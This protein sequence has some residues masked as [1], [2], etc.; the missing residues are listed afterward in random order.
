MNDIPDNPQPAETMPTRPK[1]SGRFRSVLE[2]ITSISLVAAAVTV[3]WSHFGRVTSTAAPP[4]SSRPEIASPA[5][6]QSLDGAHL[7]GN[8]QA[9]VGMI[10]YS[11]F[12]CP[13]CGRFARD[14]L[15]KLDRTYVQTGRVVFGFR[16]LPLEKIHPFAIKAAEAAECGAG[17]GRF[18]EMHDAMFLGT[19][20]LDTPGLLIAA[21]VAGLNTNEAKACIAADGSKAIRE[22][23]AR[24]AA[25][26]LTST[27]V[28]LIGRI[29]QGGVRVSKVLRGAQPFESFAAVLDPLFEVK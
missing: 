24:A 19:A 22:D 9:P 23:M 29:E 8:L 14:I 18:W 16:H 20:T 1:S 10:A 13:F 7:K 27:P 5:D 4:V 3:L 11:D 12:Q 15:P 26:N 2:V 6:L 17:Q 25:L 21:R 28:F